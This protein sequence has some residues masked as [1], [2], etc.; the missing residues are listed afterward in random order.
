MAQIIAW[1]EAYFIFMGVV[2]VIAGA[3]LLMPDWF[4]RRDL[5]IPMRYVVIF[6]VVTD[7]IVICISKLDLK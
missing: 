1:I 6:I 5:H 2:A 7:M 4:W 3:G